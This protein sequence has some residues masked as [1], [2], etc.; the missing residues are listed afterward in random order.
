MV[1]KPLIKWFLAGQLLDILTTIYGVRYVG[2]VE[3]NFVWNFNPVIGIIYKALVIILVVLVVH[4]NTEFDHAWIFVVV[5]FLPV[6]NNFIQM[7]R[8]WLS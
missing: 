7:G 3:L 6:I 1:V 4:K 2:M 8:Y 5:T